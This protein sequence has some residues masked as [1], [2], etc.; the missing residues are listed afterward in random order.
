MFPKIRILVGVDGSP[1]AKKALVE[2]VTVADL[3]SGFIRIVTFYE[4]GNEKKAHEVIEEAINALENRSIKYEAES[5]FGSNPA[6]ALVAMAKQDN[7]DLIV[8]G[9][10]GL[11]GKVSML[12]GS[13]SKQVVSDAQCNV[14]VVK[15]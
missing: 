8:V 11:G 1:Q 9:S 7:F 14:L 12:L 2:A 5:V 15:K 13:V 10:R 6:K 3:F 4:K